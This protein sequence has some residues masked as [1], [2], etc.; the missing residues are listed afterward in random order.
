MLGVRYKYTNLNKD[1]TTNVSY[2]TNRYSNNGGGSSTLKKKYASK[3]SGGQSSFSINSSNKQYYTGK[4]NSDLNNSSKSCLT[5]NNKTTISVKNYHALRQTRFVN[6]KVICNVN[7]SQQCYKDSNPELIDLSINKHFN[8]LNDTI[9]MKLY[10]K[11]TKCFYNDSETNNISCDLSGCPIK[12]YKINYNDQLS[13]Q[14]KI[15]N[16]TQDKNTITGQSSD[17]SNYYSD[18]NLFKKK[19][20]LYNPPNAKIIAC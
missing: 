6:D 10:L 12:Y 2:N 16:V 11:K 7:N 13:R 8:P 15:H 17:Y 3:I 18:S 19:N 4:P 14:S 5:S 9:S 20:C 1:N